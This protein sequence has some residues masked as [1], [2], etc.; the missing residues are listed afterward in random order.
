MCAQTTAEYSGSRSQ[1]RGGS[2]IGCW[3]PLSISLT[4]PSPGCKFSDEEWNPSI[5]L[6]WSTIPVSC[7][8]EGLDISGLR[9]GDGVIC[10]LS[11]L[12]GASGQ[13]HANVRTVVGLCMLE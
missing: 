12:G 3:I 5:V 1:W 4:S 10:G 6:T 11:L 8:P 7:P 9:T 13:P 2:D